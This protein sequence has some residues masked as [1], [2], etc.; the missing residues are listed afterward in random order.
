[1]VL[2]ETG[3]PYLEDLLKQ[4][5]VGFWAKL[6]YDD[7]PRLSKYILSLI[8]SKN[9]TDITENTPFKFPWL[10]LVKDTLD[11]LG[12][13]QFI[14]N[15]QP[16]DPKHILGK[17]KSRLRDTRLQSWREETDSKPV[18]SFYMKIK[19]RPCI[20]KFLCD[21]MINKSLR[22][23]MSRFRTRCNSLPVTRNRFNPCAASRLACELCGSG[24]IGD[25]LHY[26]FSCK[27]FNDERSKFIPA[28]YLTAPPNHEL[29]ISLFGHD[30][31]Q[32]RC[33]VAKFCKIVM[34]KFKIRKEPELSPLKVR[35]T[36]IMASGRISKRPRHLDDFF[37]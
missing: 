11:E 23:A 9:G 20:D 37:V 13:S 34:R 27:F 17:V 3:Q 6:K 19:E 8:S 36:H 24:E 22:T 2:G 28:K 33:R 35:S 10:E 16:I 26:L 32:I 7:T 31:I 14:N 4:R 12:L 21:P 25:E 1:M 18:C 5:I 15:P 29:A 30:D